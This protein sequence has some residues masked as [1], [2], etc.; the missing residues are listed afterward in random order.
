[1]TLTL[2]L[3]LTCISCV[4]TDLGK[5]VGISGA[6][7]GAAIVYIIPCDRL[8]VNVQREFLSYT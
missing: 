3:L 4:L 5:V 2:L 8:W 1:M 6:V 7:L